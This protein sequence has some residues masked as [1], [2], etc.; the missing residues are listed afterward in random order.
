MLH[1]AIDGKSVDYELLNTCEFTSARRRMSVIVR[2]PDGKIRLYCKGADTVILDKLSE[3][4]NSYL[5]KTNKDLE[6][7]AA[8][9]LRTLCLAVR[10]I[11]DSEYEKWAPQFDEAVTSLT[12][13]QEKVR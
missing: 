8:D 5:E 12:N 1:L 10:E 6:T 7:F 2:C 11:S 9:G 4:N 13:R 3:N